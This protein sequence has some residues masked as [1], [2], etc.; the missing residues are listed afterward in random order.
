MFDTAQLELARQKLE[1]LAST[2]T[3]HFDPGPDSESLMSRTMATILEQIV[4]VGAGSLRIQRT[5]AV[6][7]AGWPSFSVRNIQY[8]A[9]PTGQELDPFLE[10]L[11]ALSLRG[12][13]EAAQAVLAAADLDPQ[14]PP[15]LMELLIA[16]TCPNCPSAVAACGRVAVHWPQVSLTVIDVQYFTEL[17]GSCKSVPTVIIDHA[18]TIVGVP[19][20][21]ELLQVLKERG[22]PTHTEKALSSM[23]E[24]GRLTEAIPLLVSEN[25]LAAIPQ[26]MSDG[27]M[28]QR[29]GVMLLAEQVLEQDQHCLDGAVPPLLL[30]L[31]AKDATLRG[32]TADLLG[33]IGA[34]GAR[35]ALTRLMHDENE[36]VQ[37]VAAE[38]LASLRQPS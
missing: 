37:E 18:R 31:E 20:G 4:T 23:I 32:D 12:S 29:M 36:D 15:A 17:A 6:R 24:A 19:S 1:G 16:P 13:G 2:L 10:L 28:Q 34:P 25:G 22:E 8:L 21:E 30:L 5:S 11:V 9:I 7:Y 35:E 3:V 26:L 38:A 14:F 27:S 33:K